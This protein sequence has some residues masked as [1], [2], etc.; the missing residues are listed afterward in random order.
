MLT[1]SEMKDRMH[2]LARNEGNIAGIYNYCDRW[3]EHGFLHAY[4]CMVNSDGED[5]GS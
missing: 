4:R 5:D 1:P 3:C 2:E